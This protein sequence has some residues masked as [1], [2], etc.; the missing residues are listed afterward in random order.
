MKIV[1]EVLNDKNFTIEE[2]RELFPNPILL[3]QESEETETGYEE[4]YITS[5]N[6]LP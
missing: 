1:L 5:I 6:D 3:N 2:I 4:L